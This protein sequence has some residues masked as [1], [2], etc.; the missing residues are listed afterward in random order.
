[1]ILYEIDI[2]LIDLF[3]W[4]IRNKQYQVWITRLHIVFHLN[5]NFLFDFLLKALFKH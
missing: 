1:M 3:F 2:Y 5:L 4:Q